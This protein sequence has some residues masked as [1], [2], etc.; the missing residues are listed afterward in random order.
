M[1]LMLS[2]RF[3]ELNCPFQTMQESVC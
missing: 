2:M 3:Y 1:F